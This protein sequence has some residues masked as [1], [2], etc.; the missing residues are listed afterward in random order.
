MAS[1]DSGL[2]KPQEKYIL[3]K[4]EFQINSQ[5]ETSRQATIL[6]A[7]C[8][9]IGASVK[10]SAYKLLKGRV[11]LESWH[12]E[13][14]DNIADV[15][16]S[17]DSSNLPHPIQTSPPMTTHNTFYKSSFKD[18][19]PGSVAFTAIMEDGVHFVTYWVSK[20]PFSAEA[21]VTNDETGDTSIIFHGNAEQ[22]TVLDKTIY[23][24][25]SQGDN[26]NDWDIHYPT[27]NGTP[28]DY[29]FL[30][31]VYPSEITT[32]EYLVGRFE[33]DMHDAGGTGPGSDW[34][35][36]GDWNPNPSTVLN[37]D[38]GGALSGR[39]NDPLHDNYSY[40]PADQDSIAEYGCG[41]DGGHG[42]GGGAGASTI[43]VRKF[44]TDKANSK[45]IVAR[46]KRHGYGSGGGKGGKGGDGC[47]L[48]Y[49]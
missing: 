41:G 42:G 19:A 22:K 27:T 16:C 40:I 37:V 47:I 34:T 7:M 3:G 39:H 17:V 23:V 20:N 6:T 29:D 1:I 36:P 32:K 4:Y 28:N 2:L 12:V 38:V 18:T 33:I 26:I 45:N 44:G 46:P 15:Y 43:I 9:D 14:N 21:L 48:I 30:S 13:A 35:D 24:V 5:Y 25:S 11:L 10:P 8:G 49:Y 31:V